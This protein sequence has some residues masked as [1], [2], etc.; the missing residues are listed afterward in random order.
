MFSR[1][2]SEPVETSQPDL[3]ERVVVQDDVGQ[4]DNL[5]HQVA[6]GLTAGRQQPEPLPAAGLQTK[7]NLGGVVGGGLA[8]LEHL[9]RGADLDIS[10]NKIVD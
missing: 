2:E 10:N 9:G 3:V 1:K 6:V 5:G 8:V 4:H 7:A